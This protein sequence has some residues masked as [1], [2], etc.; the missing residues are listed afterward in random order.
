MLLKGG[1]RNQTSSSGSRPSRLT[2]K[3]ASYDHMDV[4]FN[5][6]GCSYYYSSKGGSQAK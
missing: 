3:A 1:A 2:V 4:C 5:S 6:S